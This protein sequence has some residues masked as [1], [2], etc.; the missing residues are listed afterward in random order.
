[1]FNW[2]EEQR[3]VIETRNA[4]ILVSAAAGSGKTAVLVERI[5]RLICDEG[6]SLDELIVMTFTKAAAQEMRE[7]VDKALHERLKADPDN[8]HIRTQLACMARARI[9]TI[10][11]LCQHLIKQYYQY[12]D[13]DPGFRVADD[14]ELKIMQADII[15][16]LLEEKYEEASPAFMRLADTFSRKADDSGIAALIKALFSFAESKTFPKRFL[17][18]LSEEADRES[19]GEYESSEWFD[20]FMDYI[21]RSMNDYIELLEAAARICEEPDGPLKYAGYK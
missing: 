14:G 17:E 18:E 7:R 1:M 11:S 6:V 8:A 5:A 12:L 13:I 16:A 10:D 21:R 15:S 3:K 4:D 20:Y 9:S 19:S 2:S